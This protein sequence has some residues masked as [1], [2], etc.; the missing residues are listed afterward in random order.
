MLKPN[1][2]F[3]CRFEN[4]EKHSLGLACYCG[5]LN[6]ESLCFIG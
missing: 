4:L 5:H 1:F 2:S 6:M 3:V